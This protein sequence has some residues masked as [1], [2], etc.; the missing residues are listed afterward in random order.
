MTPL[1]FKLHRVKLDISTSSRNIKR[2]KTGNW[3][4]NY[5]CHTVSSYLETHQ[6]YTKCTQNF[7]TKFPHNL[8]MRSGKPTM[9]C[10]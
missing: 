5:Y 8:T 2:N 9:S 7:F 1:P 4:K 6:K 10:A 3:K